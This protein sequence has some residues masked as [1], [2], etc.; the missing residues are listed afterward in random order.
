MAG[1]G[2]ARGTVTV[3]AVIPN[4]NGAE[5][6]ASVLDSLRAQRLPPEVRL[7]ALVVDNGSS[8]GSLEVAHGLGARTLA[9]RANRGVSAALNRGIEATSGEWIALLN[10]DVELDP[11]WLAR[12][13]DGAAATGAWYVTGKICDAAR[14][15]VIDGAGDGVCCGGSAWRLGHGRRD[16]PRFDAPRATFFPSATACLFRRRF[17]ELAGLF[18]E[19]FFAY[20]EDAELG[21][22]AAANGL[23]GAYWPQ[24]R[25][26]HRGSA[27]AGP[28]SDAMVGW[29]THHQWLLLAKH[30]SQRML[31]EFGWR[32]AAAQAL[33]LAQAVKRGRIKAW[34]RGAAA[35]LADCRNQWR[36]ETRPGEERLAA[37]LRA[38]EREIAALQ[39]ETGWDTY[40]RW[41][42]LLGGSGPEQSP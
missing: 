32:V 36:P 14:R 42:F 33:W 23:V 29:I 38:S 20:L 7:Q 35:G 25:A 15:D 6:L 4:W 34:L 22:R 18:D 27:T 16:G 26:W 17:F 28:W 10:N 13:L 8:D 19:E 2:S 39:A 21:M 41:Y 24:A 37:A 11:H 9:L 40:W 31:L 5:L 3:S 1:E 12:A 30:F